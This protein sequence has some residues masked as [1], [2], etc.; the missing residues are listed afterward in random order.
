MAK[1]KRPRKRSRK[2]KAG[3][4]RGDKTTGKAKKGP[5]RLAAEFAAELEARMDAAKAALESRRDYITIRNTQ[6]SWRDLLQKN[7]KSRAEVEMLIE[8][9]RSTT[10]FDRLMRRAFED[11]IAGDPLSEEYFPKYLSNKLDTDRENTDTSSIGPQ[12]GTGKD[13]EGTTGNARLRKQEREPVDPKVANPGGGPR[14]GLAK[15]KDAILS[16]TQISVNARH[17][18][19][20][21]AKPGAWQ[22][23]LDLRS[24]RFMQFGYL[25]TSNTD[26]HN[27]FA[28]VEHGTGRYAKPD[29]RTEGKTKAGDNSGDWYMRPS[30]GGA[31]ILWEGQKGWHVF[32][33]PITLEPTR[34][35]AKI[36][37]REFTRF[38]KKKFQ[39]P[40]NP[41]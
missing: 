6:L 27:W 19:V 18:V 12:M 16:T 37:E 40:T 26:L 13:E 24:E 3:A 17:N 33:D 38:L 23:I 41:K 30:R 29:V 2:K 22:Q 35:F 11:D 10:N 39:K 15:L 32:Y 21:G 20:F 31:S 4:K 36:F 28:N 14:L 25:S 7:V 9:F 5:N 1:G 34:V 8:E